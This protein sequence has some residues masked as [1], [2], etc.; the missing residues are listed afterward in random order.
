MVR[1]SQYGGPDDALLPNASRIRN[2]GGA[3][4]VPGCSTK[5]RVSVRIWD[6]QPLPLCVFGDR[7]KNRVSRNGTYYPVSHEK[8]SVRRVNGMTRSTTLIST[9]R[10]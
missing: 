9:R 1:H 6:A 2:P 3:R 4:S 8:L 5:R 10:D 7:L